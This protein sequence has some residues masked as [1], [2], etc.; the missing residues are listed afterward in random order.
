VGRL[1]T[2][3][4]TPSRLKA[5]SLGAIIGQVKSICTKR[6]WAIGQTDFAWQARFYDH[7]IRNEASLK[8]IREYIVNNPAKWKE[9]EYYGNLSL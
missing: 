1:S 4:T 3:T 8:R 7:I 9:D 6:I 5:G 2:T